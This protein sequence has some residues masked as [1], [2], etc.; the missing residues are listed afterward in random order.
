MSTTMSARFEPRHNSLNALR[1]LLASAVIVSHSWPLSGRT[2][3]PEFGGAN[4]GTWAVFGFFGISGYLITRSRLNGRPAR[5]FYRARVLR[6]MPAF[7]VALL[8]VAFV[9]APLSQLLDPTAVWNPVSAVTFVARN[10]F[11]YPPAPIAQPGIVET[12][13]HVPYLHLWDGSLWTLFWEACCYLGIGIGASL[14]PRVS[15][16]WV[17]LGGFVLGT[18][19]LVACTA[20][21]HL[22][23]G[24][25]AKLVLP[26]VL[27]FFGGMLVLLFGDRIKQNAV[28]VAIAA[29]VL[30][31]VILLGV[32]PLFAPLPLAYLLLVIGNVLPLSRVGSKFDISYG[33]YIYAWPVQQLLALAGAAALPLP[34]YIVLVFV[35]TVPLAF[36]SCWLIERPAL[37]LKSTRDVQRSAEEAP[38]P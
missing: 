13:N 34:V 38:T 9:F 1:L 10:L 3:E 29:V 20:G 12:L 6:I 7:I 27:A 14:L 35:G 19:Y 33:V 32:G 8:L 22:P 16:K 18:I 36:L 15:L 24:E 2:P 21:V 5:D 23:V 30:L 31:G 28:T 17:A 26:M 4:L 11:L 25:L 37:R